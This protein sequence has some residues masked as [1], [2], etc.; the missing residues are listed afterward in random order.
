ME[1]TDVDATQIDLSNVSIGSFD[2][3]TKEYLESFK[4]VSL[5]LFYGCEL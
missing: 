4:K 2:A 5:A 1:G 3:E